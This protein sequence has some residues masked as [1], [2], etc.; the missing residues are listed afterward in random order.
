MIELC[1]C[2]RDDAQVNILQSAKYADDIWHC[3]WNMAKIMFSSYIFIQIIIWMVA[4]ATNMVRKMHTF[5][6]NIIWTSSYNFRILWKLYYNFDFFHKIWKAYYGALRVECLQEWISPT[7]AT[8]VLE[9]K[10][11]SKY[12]SYPLKHLKQIYMSYICT[13]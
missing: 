13:V 12:I 1:K 10:I 11:W 4:M 9:N 3:V 2:C 6:K 8:P 5:Q 7:C